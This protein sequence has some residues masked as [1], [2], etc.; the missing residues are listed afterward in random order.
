MKFIQQLYNYQHLKEYSVIE[1]A[2]VYIML[3]YLFK[4]NSFN[5]Q[6]E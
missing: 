5:F 2:Y 1:L 4:N 6:F 3:H